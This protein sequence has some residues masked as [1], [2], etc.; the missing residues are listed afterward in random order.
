[1]RIDDEQIPRRTDRPPVAS[2]DMRGMNWPSFGAGFGLGMFAG[3]AL[4]AVAVLAGS[5]LADRDDTPTAAT[6]TSTAAPV[7]SDVRSGASSAPADDPEPAAPS[8]TAEAQAAAS[9]S[10][11]DPYDA[12][13][14]LAADIPD[15]PEISR[16]DAQA[17]ALLGCGS[18]WAP[19]T[20]DAALQ[21][22]YAVLIEGWTA[23][24]MCG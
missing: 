14:T 23:Q 4:I 15:A 1:M 5:S 22:A 11:G 7:V 21:E 16:D 17:R 18:D 9:G 12:Y 3:A 19:G 20:V 2:I 8:T 10:T 6:T 13:L 24:G